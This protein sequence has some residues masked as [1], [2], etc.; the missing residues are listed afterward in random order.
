MG[1]KVDVT[2]KYVCLRVDFAQALGVHTLHKNVKLA[3]KILNITL[4]AALNLFLTVING[5]LQNFRD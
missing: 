2:R 1:L 4:V 5:Y 3:L